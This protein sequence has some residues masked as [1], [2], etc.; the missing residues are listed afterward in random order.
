MSFK[1]LFLTIFLD[2]L[3]KNRRIEGQ[4][5]RILVK[6]HNFDEPSMSASGEATATPD[7]VGSGN[8]DREFQ[9]DLLE[10]IPVPTRLFQIALR[11]R[12]L[13]DDL[14]QEALA[15][16][17]QSRDT[18]RAGSNL[19]AWLF[20]ILRNQFI[21]IV[22]AHGAKHPGTTALAERMACCPRR[23]NLGGAAIGYSA[24]A[25]RPSRGTAR[26]IDIGG[27]W[28]VFLTKKGRCGKK[29]Q[30]LRGRDCEESGRAGE[31]NM[32]P[33]PPHWKGP[34]RCRANTS[35][36]ERCHQ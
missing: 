1:S 2:L 28:M 29:N 26:G 15:K 12:E 4:E 27:R 33:C 22:D 19:K 13:A 10:L 21:L 17:W 31:A 32:V 16:A 34:V 20:T 30:Q 7:T 35:G 11:D 18:F 6:S 3:K 5:G 9:R 23:T 8:T 36:R 25:S 24:C 14:A